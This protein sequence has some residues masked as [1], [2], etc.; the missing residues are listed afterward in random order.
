MDIQNAI[1]SINWT[2]S[3]WDLFVIIVLVAG[4]FL[5][6]TNLG[7]DRVFIV[8]I[9]GYISLALVSKFSLAREVLGIQLDGSF[10]NSTAVFIGGIILL[11]FVFLNSSFTSVF[12]RGPRGS[13]FQTAVVSF[14]QIGFMISVIVSFLSPEE[15]AALSNF[16]KFFFIENQAQFIWLVSPLLAIMI[17]KR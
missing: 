14:L 6:N 15:T 7:R 13:W 8:L 10:V 11:F 5:Y 17:F 4:V 3:S 16:I 12:D 1:N 2:F 9:S